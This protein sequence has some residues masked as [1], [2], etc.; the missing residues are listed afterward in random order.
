MHTGRSGWPP[1]ASGWPTATA[2]VV[3][4]LD[5]RLT[6][7][8]VHR[9]RRPQRLRQVHPAA[10]P[11]PAAQAAP[12]AT[13]LLDGQAHRPASR[14]ARSPRCSACCPRRPLAPEGLTVADLVARGRHPHQSWLRQWSPDDEAVVTRRWPDRHGRPRRPRRSTSS[15]AG[16]GSGPGS[17]WRWP[18]APTCCC[19]TSRPPTSTSPTRS[20]SST[21]SAGCTRERGRTVVVVLHDLNLAARY[22]ERLVAM[23]DGGRRR[24][25]AGRGAHRGAAGRG[26]RPG[27]QVIATR[28]RAPRWSS[29]S[30]PGPILRADPGSLPA[31]ARATP[32][33]GPPSPPGPLPLPDRFPSPVRSPAPPWAFALRRCGPRSVAE[34]RVDERLGLERGQVVRR[35]RRARPA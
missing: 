13:V 20:T 26:V 35:P 6:E 18:R 22:A 19:S 10:R 8:L 11:G 1:R 33:V 5:L 21:W 24:G 9:D 2:V 15:P 4:D 17:R 3:D 25:H 29:P 27:G 14:P 28:W 31:P 30:A 16:S 23:K 34:E 32:D 12:A 7:R